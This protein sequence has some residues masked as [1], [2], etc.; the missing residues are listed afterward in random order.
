MQTL[1][2]VHPT[3]SGSNI[4]EGLSFYLF[5]NVYTS[6]DFVLLFIKSEKEKKTPS[7]HRTKELN[8]NKENEHRREK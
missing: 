8:E 6:D 5:R 4:T 2:N 1:W 7:E 3:C